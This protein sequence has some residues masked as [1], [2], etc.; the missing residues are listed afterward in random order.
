MSSISSGPST[1]TTEHSAAVSHEPS[2]ASLAD[3]I[4]EEAITVP[5]LNDNNDEGITKIVA[6]VGRWWYSTCYETI[7]K[8]ANPAASS[9]WDTPGLLRECEKQGTSFR[10]LICCAQKPD[11]T[12]RRTVSV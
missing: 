7:I 2:T 5:G 4:K 3:L 12:P 6:K 9:I 11:C 10:L 8:C 1:R